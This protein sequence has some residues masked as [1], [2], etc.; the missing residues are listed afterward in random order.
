[1]DKGRNQNQSLQELEDIVRNRICG[2]CSDR[3]V[4]GSCGLEDPNECA[5][6]RLFPQVAQ[7]IQSTSSDDVN[8]Y[9]DAIRHTVCAVCADEQNDGTCDKRHEVRCS[10]DAYL[11]LV[12]DAIE[13][14]TG[15]T[16]AVRTPRTG[17]SQISEEVRL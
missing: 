4:D 17:L 15:K 7:A 5:L 10:L 8:D 11:L 2:V 1:M 12:I 16:F 9:I 13:E 6:F 3:A 14:A